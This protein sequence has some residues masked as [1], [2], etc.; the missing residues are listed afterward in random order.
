MT[1]AEQATLTTYIRTAADEMGLRDWRIELLDEPCD[2]DCNAQVRLIYGRKVATVRVSGDFRCFDL[3]RIRRTVVHELVHLHFAAMTNQVEHDL[4]GHLSKQAL[5]IF[6]SAWAR[7][8]EYGVDAIATAFAV[9]MPLI[10]WDAK[11]RPSTK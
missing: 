1:K 7:D 3:E 2:E 9:H 10:D 5:D 6:F 8:F 11:A 4:D